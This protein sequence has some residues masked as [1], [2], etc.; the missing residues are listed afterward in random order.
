MAYQ[1]YSFDSTGFD[2]AYAQQ[3][4][5]TT[6]DPLGFT[7]E[8]L[9]GLDDFSRALN[10][11][12][13][14]YAPAEKYRQNGEIDQ[15][16][17]GESDTSKLPSPKNL[18]IESSTALRAM[19][20]NALF[21]NFGI[22]S[23]EE[24]HDSFTR[25]GELEEAK[26]SNPLTPAEAL[27]REK[28][29][30]LLQAGNPSKFD[31]LA[32]LEE[33]FATSK[34]KEKAEYYTV[35]EE[36]PN[37]WFSRAEVDNEILPRLGNLGAKVVDAGN[38]L[39]SS[40]RKGY[41]YVTGS[42][43]P[44]YKTYK[45]KETQA[46]Y[47]YKQN[48]SFS[49]IP[50][51]I[52]DEIKN[53]G[54]SGHHTLQYNQW[55]SNPIN[56]EKAENYASY[57][58]TYNGLLEAKKQYDAS[59][60]VADPVS[61][62]TSE[63][64]LAE[65]SADM[66]L[67]R[68]SEN[69]SW[70]TV[71]GVIGNT[72][73]LLSAY[74]RAAPE[75]IADTSAETFAAGIPG[76]F[77]KVAKT[78]GILG[79]IGKSAVF[80]T[81]GTGI[82]TSLVGS[83]IPDIL[84]DIRTSK[85]GTVGSDIDDPAIYAFAVGAA[86]ADYYGDV[87][88]NK[89]NLPG[90][91]YAEQ[92]AAA[93]RK[94]GLKEFASRVPQ[95]VYELATKQTP[96]AFVQALAPEIKDPN[97]IKHLASIG[98]DL[99]KEMAGEAF[100][101]GSSQYLQNV[102][103]LLGQN[104][105]ALDPRRME[106]MH[107]DFT[108]AFRNAFDDSVVK[109]AAQ[110]AAV[111][112]GLK[113]T[114]IHG[115]IARSVAGRRDYFNQVTAGV[116][117][118]IDS[119][120][121]AALLGPDAEV[122][123]FS[124]TTP[125]GRNKASSG[126]G[127]EIFSLDVEG[128]IKQ[129]KT[130]RTSEEYK[131]ATQ[132]GK[133]FRNQLLEGLNA[134]LD[135]EDLPSS[136]TDSGKADETKKAVVASVLSSIISNAQGDVGQIK[137]VLKQLAPDVNVDT[138]IKQG[139]TAL[140]GDSST[141]FIRGLLGDK[142]AYTSLSNVLWTLVSKKLKIG[143]GTAQR[144]DYSKRLL[145]AYKELKKD[146]KNTELREKF[147]NYLA[148][149][150]N[151]DARETYNPTTGAEYTDE[152]RNRA[153][154]KYVSTRN[155]IDQNVV[156]A[157]KVQQ[158]IDLITAQNYLH[159]LRGDGG[160]AAVAAKTAETLV[161]L[162][163]RRANIALSLTPEQR[164][165]IKQV[166]TTLD[167]NASVNFD[168]EHALPYI[169]Q[170][171]PNT[172]LAQQDI[173]AIKNALEEIAGIQR[174]EMNYARAG[175]QGTNKDFARIL[176]ITNSASFWED[177]T[178]NQIANLKYHVDPAIKEVS[179]A[180][181]QFEAALETKFHAKSGKDALQKL[182]LLDTSKPDEKAL[183]DE[184]LDLISKYSTRAIKEYQD[185]LQAL[186]DRIDTIK[187]QE[188][189]SSPTEKDQGNI[190]E[191]SKNAREN[192]ED[193]TKRAASIQ[194]KIESLQKVFDS[195]A[196]LRI[197]PTFTS[198][199]FA[200]AT[201]LLDNLGNLQKAI[202]NA[203]N[204][205]QAKVTAFEETTPISYRVADQLRK[206][207]QND[208]GYAWNESFGLEGKTLEEL[209]NLK[210]ELLEK[211]NASM[212][213]PS[214]QETLRDQIKTIEACE[215]DLNELVSADTEAVTKG[216]KVRGSEEEESTEKESK[217]S[218][219]D[220]KAKDIEIDGEAAANKLQAILI[221]D[222]IGSLANM[223]ETAW[224]TKENS[225]YKPKNSSA[226]LLKQFLEGN[227]GLLLSIGFKTPVN[228]Y[229]KGDKYVTKPGK[230]TKS[231]ICF[232]TI[233]FADAMLKRYKMDS[234]NPSIDL[235]GLDPHTINFLAALYDFKY[236]I[237][238]KQTAG[239][240]PYTN[241]K[242]GPKACLINI[243]PLNPK[244]TSNLYSDAKLADDGT[245]PIRIPK[246]ATEHQQVPEG[247]IE[248][249]KNQKADIDSYL[250]D[251]IDNEENQKRYQYTEEKLTA[252]QKAEKKKREEEKAALEEAKKKAKESKKSNKDYSK[253]FSENTSILERIK[254]K[255]GNIITK[256]WGNEESSWIRHKLAKIIS[257]VFSK[258]TRDNHPFS[259]APDDLSLDVKVSISLGRNNPIKVSN[260][261]LG[262]ANPNNIKNGEASILINKDKKDAKVIQTLIDVN[263]PIKEEVVITSA[264]ALG[265]GSSSGRENLKKLETTAKAA[266]L[267]RGKVSWFLGNL[268][269][270][271]DFETRLT[272]FQEAALKAAG[273]D[274][275]KD[276]LESADI[277]NFIKNNEKYKE[278]FNT[279]FTNDSN[280]IKIANTQKGSEGNIEKLD[281]SQFKRV[282]AIFSCTPAEY[283]PNLFR[284][285][286]S[287]F[288]HDTYSY[289]NIAGMYLQQVWNFNQLL[290]NGYV[291]VSI[292]YI[293]GTTS[294]YTVWLKSPNLSDADTA[295]VEEYKNSIKNLT[296]KLFNTEGTQDS[297]GDVLVQE[298]T[299]GESEEDSYV[300]PEIDEKSEAA[301][302]DIWLQGVKD[303]LTPSDTDR[304]E[305]DVENAI[306]S[307][308]MG[309]KEILNSKN[310]KKDV[311]L[312]ELHR[313]SGTNSNAIESAWKAFLQEHGEN[314]KIEDCTYAQL[315]AMEESIHNFFGSVL[316]SSK[317]ELDDYTHDL[318]NSFKDIITT[319]A[320]QKAKMAD[321]AQ[322]MPYQCALENG[323]TVDFSLLHSLAEILGNI[324]EKSFNGTY[325][326]IAG[327]LI[328]SG[329]SLES[330][331]GAPLSK[332]Y[333]QAETFIQA[334]LNV[335][336][337][338]VR[339]SEI[340]DKYK[341]IIAAIKEG[342]IS[343]DG[344]FTKEQ[345]KSLATTYK[346]YNPALARFIEDLMDSKRN[347]DDRALSILQKNIEILEAYGD[348]YLDIATSLKDNDDN[349][350]A[351]TDDFVKGEDYVK[352]YREYVGEDEK[353][354]F[355]QINKKVIP[356]DENMGKLIKAQI[357]PYI[358]ALAQNPKAFN[359][360]LGLTADEINEV[361]KSLDETIDNHIVNESANSPLDENE[362]AYKVIQFAMYLA[363]K[364]NVAV[365]VSST[366]RTLEST[367]ALNLREPKGELTK[368]SPVLRFLCAGMTEE[369]TQEFIEKFNN[370]L[371][372]EDVSEETRATLAQL[373]NCVG[374]QS[375]IINDIG[376]TII[377]KM[378]P[379]SREDLGS[380]KGLN[381]STFREDL[382]YQLG[383]KIE[384][385]L[386]ADDSSINC[387][388]NED[389]DLSGATGHD[390]EVLEDLGIRKQFSIIVPVKGNE[391]DET[392]LGR[393]LKLSNSKFAYKFLDCTALLT[394]VKASSSITCDITQI[395]P[396]SK[397]SKSPGEYAAVKAM[398]LAPNAIRRSV[399]EDTKQALE[400]EFGGIPVQ[401][402]FQEILDYNKKDVLNED[403]TRVSSVEAYR[404]IK[405]KL[406]K[407]E[408]QKFMDF[409][410]FNFGLSD[411]LKT[412]SFVQ[413]NAGIVTN[414]A[415]I[416]EALYMQD[417]ADQWQMA[418]AKMN[419]ILKANSTNADISD[420]DIAQYKDSPFYERVR[421][422]KEKINAIEPNAWDSDEY[423][424]F[425]GEWSEGSN[426][427][428]SMLGSQF[429][430]QSDKKYARQKTF[431]F[432]ALGR[433]GH[434]ITD[435]SGTKKASTIRFEYPVQMGLGVISKGRLLAN[436]ICQAFGLKPEKKNPQ[437]WTKKAAPIFIRIVKFIKDTGYNGIVT[438]EIIDRF[439]TD[440][441][442][443]ELE[444]EFS[445]SLKNILDTCAPFKDV[446]LGKCI[447]P[448]GS[449]NESY[450]SNN[451][452]ALFL[453]KENTDFADFGTVSF[454]N[455]IPIEADGIT[456]GVAIAAFGNIGLHDLFTKAFGIELDSKYFQSSEDKLK[457]VGC[458]T[459]DGDVSSANRA[460]YED[461]VGISKDMYQQVMYAINF[462]RP[463]SVEGEAL[464]V[465]A[466]GQK[467]SDGEILPP[468]MLVVGVKNEKGELQPTSVTD[469]DD[470][471]KLSLNQGVVEF[472]LGK[473]NGT[474]FDKDFENQLITAGMSKDAIDQIANI[475][476]TS[477]KKS[478]W[479]TFSNSVAG[480]LSENQFHNFVKAI[481][482]QILDRNT[483]K[484]ASI[485]HNYGAAKNS[486]FRVL[487]SYGFDKYLESRRKEL[488]NKTFTSNAEIKDFLRDFVKDFL[489]NSST[490][491]AEREVIANILESALQDDVLKN[492]IIARNNNEGKYLSFSRFIQGEKLDKTSQTKPVAG[493]T[494]KGLIS[495]SS[496]S[497]DLPSEYVVLDFETTGT[498]SS[499]LPI[500][501]SI[502]K[503][504]NGKEVGRYHRYIQTDV[505]SI[506]EKTREFHEK[507]KFPL[508]ELKNGIS[509]KEANKEIR[510]FIG[511]LPVVG[512]NI[513]FDLNVL[514]HLSDTVKDKRPIE[515]DYYDTVILAAKAGIPYGARS[516]EQLAKKFLGDSAVEAHQAEQDNEQNLSIIPFLLERVQNPENFDDF[517][518]PNPL[519][520]GLDYS[521]ISVLNTVCAAMYDA[522]DLR[523]QGDTENEEG[524]VTGT[525]SLQD[526]LTKKVCDSCESRLKGFFESS[527]GANLY[528]AANRI[529]VEQR[530]ATA[531]IGQGIDQLAAIVQDTIDSVKDYIAGK[532]EPEDLIRFEN[533]KQ[534]IFSHLLL[535][536]AV[537]T[538]IGGSDEPYSVDKVLEDSNLSI[539]GGGGLAQLRLAVRKVQ[540]EALAGG[541]K[542]IHS[543][544]GIVAALVQI[545]ME[546]G[547]L[548]IHDAI[549][550]LANG[551]FCEGNTKQ[552]A[553]LRQ[554]MFDPDGNLSAN[555]FEAFA[556]Y[557][558]S[559]IQ[560]IEELISDSVSEETI[561]KL[562][563]LSDKDPLPDAS[564][565]KEE[566]KLF[567]DKLETALKDCIQQNV[568]RAHVDFKATK[569]VN[570][571]LERL[572]LK[573][574]KYEGYKDNM[575]KTSTSR[576]KSAYVSACELIHNPD[577]KISPN[578]KKK[579]STRV[580]T[581][582]KA[583]G[584]YEYKQSEVVS[585]L[586]EKYGDNHNAAAKSM[587]TNA[588][589]DN[590][591]EDALNAVSGMFMEMSPES[592]EMQGKQKPAVKKEAYFEL[593][594]REL[595][596]RMGKVKPTLAKGENEP[597]GDYI[598]RI[599]NEKGV[600][601]EIFESVKAYMEK[602]YFV[603]PDNV[604]KNGYVEVEATDALNTL[605]AYTKVLHHVGNK[606]TEAVK[607]MQSKGIVLNNYN[608]MEGET[609]LPNEAENQTG[610]TINELVD[611]I[612]QNSASMDTNR[613]V[614]IRGRLYRALLPHY[615]RLKIYKKFL[616]L[617]IAKIEDKDSDQ[618]KEFLKNPLDYVSKNAEDF[619]TLYTLADTLSGADYTLSGLKLVTDAFMPV[620]TTSTRDSS[621]VVK[622]TVNS[623]KENNLLKRALIWYNFA[624]KDENIKKENI[625]LY[626]ALGR[627]VQ[628]RDINLAHALS[629]K[630][631]PMARGSEA[632]TLEG[633]FQNILNEAEDEYTSS[634]FNQELDSETKRRNGE[635]IQS[636]TQQDLNHCFDS[637]RQLDAKLGNVSAEEAH[638][639][640]LLNKI[641]NGITGVS[642]A[643]YNSNK[644]NLGKFLLTKNQKLVVIQRA[645]ARLANSPLMMSNTEIL[646]H[647]LTHALMTL[648]PINSKEYKTL[649]AMRNTFTDYIISGNKQY[650]EVVD[651]MAN[652]L[653]N[654]AIAKNQAVTREVC[655]NQAK[656]I[657]RYVTQS[658]FTVEEF[659]AYGTTNPTMMH[660]LNWLAEERA[661]IPKYLNTKETVNGE[662]LTEKSSNLLRD[663]LNF[664]IDW[665]RK[666][667]HKSISD[668][669]QK[670]DSYTEAMCT[671]FEEIA[672]TTEPFRAIHQASRI[673]S[674][675]VATAENL[676][677]NGI[678]KVIGKVGKA[679]TSLANANVS[680]NIFTYGMSVA[681]NSLQRL[682][683][684]EISELTTHTDNGTGI[685]K[686]FMKKIAKIDSVRQ[687]SIASD[688]AF[689][690]SAF[691][692]LTS[693]KHKAIETVMIHSDIQCVL[694]D[695]SLGISL[696]N[697]ND[698]VQNKDGLLDE[699][700]QIAE[701]QVNRLATINGTDY[702]V[703]MK[704]QAKNLGYY[705]ATGDHVTV[706]DCKNAAQIAR[707]FGLNQGDIAN[708]AEFLEEDQFIQLT[709]AIDKLASLRS[710][711]ALHET[712]NDGESKH[713]FE[714]K[715]ILDKFDSVYIQQSVVPPLTK[716]NTLDPTMLKF[717]GLNAL[718]NYHRDFL[719][720]S[721]KA[722]D[723]QYNLSGKFSSRPTYL[724][725]GYT[726]DITD[727]SYNCVIAHTKEDVEHL[728]NQGYVEDTTYP[729]HERSTSLNIRMVARYPQVSKYT[730]GAF[731]MIN[732]HRAGISI[733]YAVEG[734]DL[735]QVDLN[736]D[737]S[738]M[739]LVRANLKKGISTPMDESDADI[740][741]AYDSNGTVTGVRLITPRYVQTNKMFRVNNFSRSLASA[742]ARMAEM[743]IAEET[744]KETLKVVYKE[745][746]EAHELWRLAQAG[747]IKAKAKLDRDWVEFSYESDNPDILSDY[748][749]MPE[750]MKDSIEKFAEN[751]RHP[752]YVR[753]S[754]YNLLFGYHNFTIGKF[755]FTEEQ[756][757]ACE[758]KIQK[759]FMKLTT[760]MFNQPGLGKIAVTTEKGIQMLTQ[761]AKDN[762]VIRNL[763]VPMGNMMSNIITLWLSGMNP[764]KAIS[765]S[766]MGLKNY[767]DYY[768]YQAKIA[769]ADR[770]LK[771][772]PTNSVQR[773][774]LKARR[775]E[776]VQKIND[777]PIYTYL[778]K[779]G[780]STLVEDFTPEDM[781][782]LNPVKQVFNWIAGDA[783]G[784]V[785]ED[786]NVK[787]L[788]NMATAGKGTAIHKLMST[789]TTA[790]D[791]VSK[792]A[793]Y[794][795][796]KQ[797]KYKFGNDRA[798]NIELDNKALIEA[799]EAFILYDLPTN[800]Y[801]QY[802]NDMG[803]F[804]FSKFFL[805][806]Q[807]VIFR[808][809]K[810]HPS[811]MIMGYS[812]MNGMVPFLQE[813]F[814]ESIIPYSYI[815]NP[816]KILNRFKTPWGFFN[817]ALNV[818]MS[819][820]PLQHV[821]DML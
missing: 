123:A 558:D 600:K 526:L 582:K 3:N 525:V 591:D 275:E 157:N 802:A 712:A 67:K 480:H 557:Y 93:V 478:D 185:E 426:N 531:L 501:V 190:A 276:T 316:V 196:L 407:E 432:Y 671:I 337:D 414:N 585:H 281:D 24:L 742:R 75:Y 32:D 615:Q 55:I 167:D 419:K 778:Q 96:K 360:D 251:L 174:L 532:N 641:T 529:A 56:R 657:L 546:G 441:L 43:D 586:S 291:P 450:I 542:W 45:E 214:A 515:N 550:G 810:E 342:K 150:L 578:I 516:Q 312:K 610:D 6:F 443:G 719:E 466:Q 139:Q 392:T 462:A 5:N 178:L 94:I 192:I 776:W 31:W 386:T 714:S 612:E 648:I 639:L 509:H 701:Q 27:E 594:A 694:N 574:L 225:G 713:R 13:S 237:T 278:E 158:T 446:S 37:A 431:R 249:S 118:D 130:Y 411:P 820:V 732:E 573:N 695:K 147:A 64:E 345:V 373:L 464:P 633:V 597:A 120:V 602:T 172:G 504:K 589:N 41:D 319:I 808:T 630:D 307:F 453:G 103:S 492:Y 187:N 445:S 449:L 326:R 339:R 401:K 1:P 109:A 236:A 224:T 806:I 611:A 678:R 739:K 413:A 310:Y 384:H 65:K 581:S 54:L 189:N 311:S 183:F 51:E 294:F 266:Y 238:S 381:N 779:V 548:N 245:T 530:Q 100:A 709:D 299:K 199:V 361:L 782:N 16:L 385:K 250:L 751:Q 718:L 355:I 661:L 227:N 663:L 209:G 317:K 313:D 721:K 323:I 61:Q 467:F 554:L 229:K 683:A 756:I 248:Y 115:E 481:S 389:I 129:S 740:E 358:K 201:N 15:N 347:L 182:I 699:K 83:K 812:L 427:R 138:L 111:A 234:A 556:R 59:K 197:D 367:V 128:H 485:P 23:L 149:A 372:D 329:A 292:Q 593:F 737:L 89:I 458:R 537:D 378:F 439:K 219:P 667:F 733:D 787:L 344:V 383:R 400:T 17:W 388:Q 764:V 758:N 161:D 377:K 217:D 137:A 700:I 510:D 375:S 255:A 152:E 643:L 794:E 36:N 697:L 711:K 456:N 88:L 524:K 454:D 631:L 180:F 408:Y 423:V 673:I 724:H 288:N 544:D 206:D 528:D 570:N 280:F 793:M 521:A 549:V 205:E 748:S 659:A 331:E 707:G 85:L 738:K 380:D 202:D 259:Q 629:P 435:K 568:E 306:N 763:G 545:Q 265:K 686:Q 741:A 364:R 569:E 113:L 421:I 422:A 350:A 102:G 789:L 74:S 354:G 300:E 42:D 703:Y 303:P 264:F 66:I 488:E 305:E 58:E 760:K 440:V 186:N 658:D 598:V 332:S 415:Q 536:R 136:N 365:A 193:L 692:E 579:P 184:G 652:D 412:L 239:A 267:L 132:A 8:Q 258:D 596:S 762:I 134:F 490:D 605:K 811:R 625:N 122:V 720:E 647:E 297:L 575:S 816:L 181:L 752:L 210:T 685:I 475:L 404:K 340:Y 304:S 693:S 483:V 628:A 315:Q 216:T 369:Q 722:F 479:I 704:T 496:E 801:I 809:F 590:A 30:Q 505:N 451:S 754:Q 212:Q 191:N 34:E 499:S 19:Y 106:M 562:Y 330:I 723:K 387:L 270:K 200:G 71:S 374:S 772:L 78:A 559:C 710:L 653:Y 420:P 428:Y 512:H 112:Y 81:V 335:D 595:S 734:D 321:N 680:Q 691:P 87:I 767:V 689:L 256:F 447:N 241:R 260:N 338:K 124:D 20:D 728:K 777:N 47:T 607:K 551:T 247:C 735:N 489:I 606:H 773:R 676:I 669:Y 560:R 285:W 146:P 807:K 819:T 745:Q 195:I 717:A 4:A 349:T 487:A 649:T 494:G 220:A 243:V 567:K 324:S 460:T 309:F 687:K 665:C 472:L 143:R 626:N 416:K 774:Y 805:R 49:D 322:Y 668:K 121:E 736:E 651:F 429:N 455:W 759:L 690:Q 341:E 77:F 403:I 646:V 221:F 587:V 226:T 599:Y 608:F 775:A 642:I 790:S 131:E 670:T 418:R 654:Q 14:K 539:A 21:T 84:A 233:A 604:D 140:T 29:L 253:D 70:G 144:D 176:L 151:Q 165:A 353:K 60:L 277:I 566:L 284:K 242:W 461:T 729:T 442:L 457:I 296:K 395:N 261:S 33:S 208:T 679:T 519:L 650:Q 359:N 104:G 95:A 302:A 785:I 257:N 664:V 246:D 619:T 148:V 287:N 688:S 194:G 274:P 10:L 362:P 476:K 495:V 705:L 76:R 527:I 635:Y 755:N 53:Y 731:S 40:L 624:N 90:F 508:D 655:V 684:D 743:S 116:T 750:Y 561:R 240:I 580:L 346:L 477:N 804:V 730:T 25:L 35:P 160:K 289:E 371:Y 82:A 28:L 493:V 469:L 164:N 279:T 99:M 814:N 207:H 159:A 273:K 327:L 486:Y 540:A 368:S 73:N 135:K 803:I 592:C 269:F 18:G 698:V 766:I 9:K 26:K 405:E 753:K 761:F 640:D 126:E 463:D 786:S 757:Q 39:V 637:A 503:Y 444:L 616:G 434:R 572:G 282:A 791:V 268:G 348:L 746:E 784:K 97:L 203:L 514:R 390:L 333:K 48:N 7:E 397:H 68:A 632:A 715:D 716:Q 169:L 498:K 283:S 433:K 534:R 563:G 79:Q 800:K 506:D 179:N 328:N 162:A 623:T 254:D 351:F 155:K 502:I 473:F 177:N 69:G 272:A 564:V 298:E 396:D 438:P 617:E 474:A 290:Q 577:A 62:T 523:K 402:L 215:K 543:L 410:E 370:A 156:Q 677:D 672:K 821:A 609:Y 430:P 771:Y 11:E 452:E 797:T 142:F 376:T 379:E 636:A 645:K 286:N 252:E 482:L 465:L 382:A 263:E 399:I 352:I 817:Q 154:S 293:K 555:M 644:K 726:N 520:D 363:G 818:N 80:G 308:L 603:V 621:G 634:D 571:Y 105:I 218:N 781:H 484:D 768:E 513:V 108:S 553:V 507:N 565:V 98:A 244:Q 314:T 357:K 110:G 425:W 448:D 675:G 706:L 230:H 356:V 223:F 471:F 796:L 46:N 424:F 584:M 295:N 538:P 696:D 601:R 211:Y 153:E 171:L 398:S 394:G 213:D 262:V 101:E 231:N 141:D 795:H 44:L 788:V 166:L 22:T 437:D 468:G 436:S 708:I 119:K 175:M 583:R 417:I 662:V 638:L 552:N 114:G 91:S 815:L 52:A 63:Q 682:I 459:L 533:L 232:Q 535:G 107:S 627:I 198:K 12:N 541:V 318:L 522:I 614:A 666:I 204:Q 117:Q 622:I 334:L 38:N 500:E 173:D 170:E 491:V 813:S 681:P 2:S 747:D 409:C 343:S 222:A 769:Q 588:L 301:L 618:N 656:K 325:E 727:P 133:D 620:T 145:D 576:A 271:G 320:I 235:A 391:G 497:V 57:V 163:K 660:T 50:V 674:E 518:E 798:K 547:V 765:H 725:K 393:L 511:D 517:I 799:N 72:L 744:N 749:I 366:L 228:V 770:K 336:G 406:G 780:D 188:Q 783:G 125:A 792:W 702:S 613:E 86:I 92:A 470:V 127:N 168:I